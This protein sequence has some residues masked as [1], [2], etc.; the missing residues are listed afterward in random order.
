MKLKLFLILFASSLLYSCASE[1]PFTPTEQPQQE[2]ASVIRSKEDA[3]TLAISHME[4]RTQSRAG[5]YV[6]SDIDIV[7][8]SI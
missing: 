1:E 5:E 2:N 7:L 6:V 8:I 3:I 4:A